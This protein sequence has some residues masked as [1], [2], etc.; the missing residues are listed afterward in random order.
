MAHLPRSLSEFEE[1]FD[2]EV[3]GAAPSNA[4]LARWLCLPRLR[5]DQGL[6]ARKPEPRLMNASAVAAR[7]LSRPEPFCTTP[8]LPLSTWFWAG[9]VTAT[10]PNGVSAL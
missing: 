8:K 2:D 10:Q 9:Y 6:A 5:R 1:R 7:P 3:A 4:A